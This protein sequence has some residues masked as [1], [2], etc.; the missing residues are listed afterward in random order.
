MQK[1]CN[2][3][4]IVKPTTDFHKQARCLFGVRSTCKNCVS[5][6]KAKHYQE[7]KEG[8][9]ERWALWKEKTDRSE[10]YAKY[11]QDNKEKIKAY[12]I[13][14]RHLFAKNRAIRRARLIQRT[15]SWLTDGDLFEIECIYKYC[16]SLRSLGLNYEVDHIIPLAGK[17]VSGFHV[18]TNLQVIPTSE[19]RKKANKVNAQVGIK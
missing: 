8:Y 15:P 18:P 10:Y 12:E 19:N 14:V 11:R 3:C 5:Q 2:K 4:G 13:S 6:R 7:N 16:N 1:T 9:K 17:L